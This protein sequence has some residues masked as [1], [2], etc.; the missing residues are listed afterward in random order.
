M[1]IGKAPEKHHSATGAGQDLSAAIL[2]FLFCEQPG[3]LDVLTDGDAGEANVS[4]GEDHI[5]KAIRLRIAFHKKNM[6]IRLSSCIVTCAE[7]P[8]PATRE[9]IL[10]SL[11]PLLEP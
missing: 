6:N 3:F 2:N 9:T 5:L 4:E 11:V 7:P 8:P 1:S 10:G